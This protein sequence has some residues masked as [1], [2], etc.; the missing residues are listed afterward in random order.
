MAMDY[1]TATRVLRE[2][3]ARAVSDIELPQDWVDSTAMIAS[4]R[5]KTYTPMLGTAILAR[6]VM[7]P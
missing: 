2:A 6:A 4:S 7:T 5:I 1:V 3:Y